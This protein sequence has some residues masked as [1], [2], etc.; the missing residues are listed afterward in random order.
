MQ[1][2]HTQTVPAES[3]VLRHAQYLGTA[4]ATYYRQAHR[5][6]IRWLVMWAGCLGFFA[7]FA[8][9]NHYLELSTTPRGQIAIAM[10][11]VS[12]IQTVRAM[13]RAERR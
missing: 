5:R 8:F 6:A 4:V 12:Y 10:L 7:A 11:I 3:Q 1:T 13:G 9:W 2:D